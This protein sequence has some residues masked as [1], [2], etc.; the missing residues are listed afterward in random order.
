[1]PW[2]K[3]LRKDV[4]FFLQDEL[5]KSFHNKKQDLPKATD[6][7]LRLAKPGQQ[8]VIVCD[9]SFYS[10]GFVLMI[11]DNLE[12]EDRKKNKSVHLYPTDHSYLIQIK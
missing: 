2:N 6:T 12:E 4:E 9:A 11:E 1:M 7:T 8:Y 10:S 5:L 3:L